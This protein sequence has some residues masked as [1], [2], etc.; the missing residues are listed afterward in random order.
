MVKKRFTWEMYVIIQD[1]D[2]S[3]EERLG[4]SM[5]EDDFKDDPDYTDF[6]TPV[7]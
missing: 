3:F 2:T 7:F 6:V 5:T 4:A 1:F